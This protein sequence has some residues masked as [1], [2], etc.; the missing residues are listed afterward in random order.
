VQVIQV[1]AD[2]RTAG[3]VFADDDHLHLKAG[4]FACHPAKNHPAVLGAVEI[5]LDFA[6]GEDFLVLRDDRV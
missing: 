4:A 6:G 2:H 5:A 3:G 1:A